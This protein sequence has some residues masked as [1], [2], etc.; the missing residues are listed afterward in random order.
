MPQ[1]DTLVLYCRAGFESECATELTERAAQAGFYGYP[2]FERNSG[3]ACFHLAAP[4][5]A[6]ALV[7]AIEFRSLIFTRQWIASFPCLEE[8]PTKDRLTP[9]G[10]LVA[11]LPQCSELLVEAA[12][13]TE[14][15]ELQG[16]CRKFGSALA[17]YLRQQ[18]MLLPRKQ[19]ADWRLHLFVL[20]GQRMW[21]GV[22]PVRNGSP[23]PMGIERLK[24][25][26]DAPSRSTL[27]LEEA[28]HWFVP[29]SQW[30]SRLAGGMRAVDLGAAPGGWTWQLVKR[31]M[32]VTAVDNGPMSPQLMDSGQVEH[33]REDAFV[34]QPGKPVDWMVCDVVE[35]PARTAA[36]VIDWALNGWAREMI[37]NLKLPMKQRYRE[38]EQCLRRIVAA[39]E[40][41]GVGFRLEA[42]QLYHDREEITCWL[43]L[44]PGR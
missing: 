14:G 40:E 33:R 31:G 6:L 44:A 8:L 43:M 17:S 9:I 15:R 3:Y 29:R 25:P 27:K 7:Q 24:F 2:K 10:R 1:P 37:F 42:R 34:F 16:F 30:D 41:A 20:S 18:G 35:K 11:E 22:S 21:L 5:S 32:F 12:D 38:A 26:A 19:R 4:G 28:W 13:T 39:L 36:M 23:W